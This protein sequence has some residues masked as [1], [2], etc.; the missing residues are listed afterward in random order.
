[1]IVVFSMNC[2]HV[3]VHLIIYTVLGRVRVSIILLLVKVMENKM[4]N[5]LEK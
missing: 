5:C 3:Y 1:M 2:L 4:D